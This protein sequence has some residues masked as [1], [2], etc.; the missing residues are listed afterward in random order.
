MC[1]NLSIEND[2]II[3]F[4]F[5]DGHEVRPPSSTLADSLQTTANI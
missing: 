5:F 4:Y 2:W 3:G 1:S